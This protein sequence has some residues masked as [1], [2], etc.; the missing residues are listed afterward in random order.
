MNTTPSHTKIR[1]LIKQLENIIPEEHHYLLSELNTEIEQLVTVLPD[2]LLSGEYLAKPEF[3]GSSGCYRRGQESV[4]YCPRC[5]ERQQDLIRGPYHENSTLRP[6]YHIL[7][8]SCI[9]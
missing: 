8:C 4:F 2:T 7:H 6:S 1:Q 3:D 5:Y 9:C